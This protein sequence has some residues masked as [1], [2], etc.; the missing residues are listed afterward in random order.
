MADKKVTV[1]AR[2]K[3][4]KGMEETVNQELMA[5]VAP[6]RSEKG[7]INYDL[8]RSIDDRSVFMFYENWVSKEDLDKHLA[9]PY[10]KSHMEKAR[11]MLAGPAEIT[12]WER[13]S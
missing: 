1:V 12:L 10:M 11:E 9:M 13:I 7:C 5:L 6:T 2:I 4:K 8:H 3:A